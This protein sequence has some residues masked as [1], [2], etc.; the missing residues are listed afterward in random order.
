VRE[1]ARIIAQQAER[2]T[3][4][5]RQLLDFA[6]RRASVMVSTD[7]VALGRRTFDL[8]QPLAQKH[9]VD[10]RLV[11]EQPVVR[12]CVDPGQI[13]QAL[14][15]LL[16]NAIQA[17]QGPGEVT[18]DIRCRDT[19]APPQDV[20][21]V[22]GR[23]PSAG[24]ADDGKSRPCVLFEVR[25]QGQ[26]IPAEHLSHVFEP[27]YTTKQVGEGTGLGLS[28]SYG[29]VREHGGWIALESEVN[30][31]STFTIFLP[32]PRDNEIAVAAQ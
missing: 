21:D 23:P 24:F 20:G 22:Y 6:R 28:V 25:D 15:N 4:I 16:M 12:A 32:Q 3:N 9:R 1:S 14:T 30:K 27:F 8:L 7:L 31:G 17:M 29:I 11:P 10:L 18:L 2:M 19:V 13:Q 26:G 5:I